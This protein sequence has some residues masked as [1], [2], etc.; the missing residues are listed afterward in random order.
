MRPRL[1][2]L[3]MGLAQRTA[4]PQV[5][6]LRSGP[7]AAAAAVVK[8]VRRFGRIVALES[9]TFSSCGQDVFSIRWGQFPGMLTSVG[10]GHIR[11]GATAA[12]DQHLSLPD[13][14]HLSPLIH[15]PC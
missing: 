2:A 4:P 1:L 9:L 8:L 11:L 10:V 14:V 5:Q 15:S 7:D 6:G 12:N 3:C 13:R